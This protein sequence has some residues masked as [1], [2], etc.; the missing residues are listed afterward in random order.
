MLVFPE[1]RG[2]QI[3]VVAKARNQMAIRILCAVFLLRAVIP[4]GYMPAAFADGLPFVLCPDNLPSA[5]TTA[6]GSHAHDHDDHDASAIDQ[7]DFGDL[8]PD[9]GATIDV[10]LHAIDAVP[11]ALPALSIHAFAGR[12][13]IRPI[14]RGPPA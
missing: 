5:F 2:R 14:A 6:I 9:S 10:P 4:L 13:I 1:S 11:A 12:S 3:P 8:A 7:C